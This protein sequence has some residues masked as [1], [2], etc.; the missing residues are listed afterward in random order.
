MPGPRQGPGHEGAV[1]ACK[2]RGCI[3]LNDPELTRHGGQP[4]HRLPGVAGRCVGQRKG[5]ASGDSWAA[6]IPRLLIY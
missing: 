3:K 4:R 5:Q 6:A 2:C 1:C